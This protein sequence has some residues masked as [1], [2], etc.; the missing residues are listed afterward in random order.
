MA[1]S[2]AP[3]RARKLWLDGRLRW[4]Y[5]AIELLDTKRRA[6]LLEDRRLYE[7]RQRTGATWIAAGREARIWA[8][9]AR[10]LSGAWTLWLASS[11]LQTE[12]SITVSRVHDAGVARPGTADLRLPDLPDSVRAATGAVLDEAAEAHRRALLA[13]ATHALAETA[14][15]VVHRELKATERHQRAI[16]RIRV[17]RL[18]SELA[19]LVLRLDELERQERMVSRWASLRLHPT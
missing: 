18:E 16:E 11:S 14:Y 7:E 13:A 9:R 4:A 1:E 15:Q 10:T 5:R 12:A 17:P 3:G 6:L 19:T 2:A 8:V